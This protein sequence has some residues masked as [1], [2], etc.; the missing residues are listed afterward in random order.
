MLGE[1]EHKLVVCGILLP[2]LGLFGQQP[3]PAPAPNASLTISFDDALQRARKYGIEIQT[4]NIEVLLAREDRIQAK[5]AML[6]QAES[7]NQVTYTQPNGSD[8][9]V[10]VASN[11]PRVYTVQAQAHQDF[12]LTRW[13]EYRRAIAAEAVAKTKA[14][15]VARG[16][17]ATTVQDYYAIVIAQRK[18]ANAQRTL[19]DARRFLDLTQKQERGGEAAHADV[20]K[21]E[22]QVQQRERDVLDA[23]L[24]INQARVALAVLIF[25]DFRRDYAV[26]DDLDQQP[27]LAPFA[28]IQDLAFARNP[29]LRAAQANLLVG[30]AEISV[31]RTA[32]LPALSLDYWYGIQANQFAVHNPEGMNNLGSLAQVTVTVPVWTWGAASSKIRQAQLKLK[33]GQ[34]E[35]TLAQRQLMASLNTFYLEAQLASAQLDS[36]KRSVDLAMESLRLTILRYQAGEATALE[37][38]DAQSTLAQARN[39]YDEGLSRYRVAVANLQTL[40]G[41]L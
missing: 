40:T 35:L 24:A 29:E 31:A 16:I 15:V 37:V 5:A 14:D 4:A 1:M 11:G 3:T 21:A 38:V 28:E 30:A 25:P 17:V 8:T 2:A 19:D 6:P 41:S 7:F 26:V 22:L 23:Q 27:P 10:F 36:L 12:S 9:G 32:Y 18:L 33:Q 39:A 13:A 34:L 20:V